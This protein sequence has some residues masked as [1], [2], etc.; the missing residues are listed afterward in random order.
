MANG[1]RVGI[2]D[3]DLA[4]RAGRRMVLDSVSDVTVVFEED[5]V[6]RVLELFDD[7]LL[8]VLLVEQRLRGA[9]GIELT[10]ALGKIKLESGNKTRI[11]LTTVFSSPESLLAALL[12]G[13]SD[14]VGQDEGPE[15]LIARI[16]LLNSTKPA[17][18]LKQLQTLWKDQ[19]GVAKEDVALSVFLDSLP[20]SDLE[21]L[22]KVVSGLNGSEITKVLGIAVYRVRKVLESALE[23]LQLTTL[24]QLQ[25][26]FLAAGV[27]V[28]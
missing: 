6:S 25:L 10:R 26:R 12:A 15:A 7:Y 19:D 28:E 2:V 20:T 11:L 24:E 4:I 27:S 17:H 1:I 8:D 21:L 16:R 18:D 9:S 13:A 14:V 23:R 3:A 22:K 5:S